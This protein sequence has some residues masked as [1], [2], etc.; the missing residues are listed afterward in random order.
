MAKQKKRSYFII[1]HPTRKK[2]SIPLSLLK[3]TSAS[4]HFFF[5]NESN[6]SFLGDTNQSLVRFRVD[7]QR[8]HT[9]RPRHANLERDQRQH[10]TINDQIAGAFL[11]IDGHFRIFLVQVLQSAYFRTIGSVF[12]HDH[13]LADFRAHRKFG[14]TGDREFGRQRRTSATNR[15]GHR[16]RLFDQIERRTKTK[17]CGKIRSYFRRCFQF[18]RRS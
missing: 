12:A 5:F 11:Q 16:V 7:T 8:V 14:K 6:F 9:E 3:L 1:L 2:K 10:Q 13:V 17:H 18:V 15:C 4:F